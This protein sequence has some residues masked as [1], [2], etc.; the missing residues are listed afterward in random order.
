MHG[1]TSRGPKSGQEEEEEEEE[2]EYRGSPF[3]CFVYNSSHTPAGFGR[4]KWLH[5]DS[6]ALQRTN[7]GHCLVRHVNGL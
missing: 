7:V 5:H 4:G 2:E 6:E 3:D 1:P